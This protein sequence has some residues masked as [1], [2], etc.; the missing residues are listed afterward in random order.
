MAGGSRGSPRPSYRAADKLDRNRGQ[1]T[2]IHVVW[3]SHSPGLGLAS[4]ARSQAWAAIQGLDDLDLC[5][6]SSIIAYPSG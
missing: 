4:V 6:R 2:Q 5:S 1:I 3:S